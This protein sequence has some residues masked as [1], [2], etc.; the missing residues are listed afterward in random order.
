MKRTEPARSAR[1]RTSTRAAPTS[2]ATC[3]PWPQACMAPSTSD[4]NGSPVS[5]RSGS[6]SM[7]ARSRIVGPG[8]PP[9]RR[10]STDVV[11]WPVRVSSPSASSASSTAAC[12]RGSVRP[13]SGWRWMRRRSWIAS[14]RSAWAS[15]RISAGF[16]S[17]LRL[18]DQHAALGEAHFHLGRRQAEVVDGLVE[19]LVQLVARVVI[20]RGL[21]DEEDV[22]DHPAVANPESLGLRVEVVVARHAH[23]R[24]APDEV[25]MNLGD[26]VFVHG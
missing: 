16:I 3:A 11:R 1:R 5:S 15:E 6:A 20:H 17:L 12:V 2:I 14:S 26:L 22:R 18:L 19:K 25:V 24:N 23:V 13:I 7:S 9:A 4:A 10:A 21:L 8:L